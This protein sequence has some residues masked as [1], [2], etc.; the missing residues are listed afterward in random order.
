M[1]SE[2]E[3]KSRKI[4][5]MVGRGREKRQRGQRGIIYHLETSRRFA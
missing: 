1:G 5:T 4:I 2:W 3:G